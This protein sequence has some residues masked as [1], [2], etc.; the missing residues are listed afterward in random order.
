MANKRTKISSIHQ[1][2]II[3]SLR[4]Q[5]PKDPGE[6]FKTSLLNWIKDKNGIV[7]RT[8]STNKVH[9]IGQPTPA[10]HPQNLLKTPARMLFGKEK[11]QTATPIYTELDD[12]QRAALTGKVKDLSNFTH[13]LRWIKS[14]A[15]LTL[16][17]EAASIV[18]QPN[19]PNNKADG[20][21]LGNGL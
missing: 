16:M 11:S 6:S 14:P 20:H 21:Y 17:K 15:E 8:Y 3:N 2:L 19:E 18:C 12:F 4:A 9:D 7:R 1:P 10:T 5:V 13:E